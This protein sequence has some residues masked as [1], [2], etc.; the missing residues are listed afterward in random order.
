[1]R[2]LPAYIA[3]GPRDGSV[4][5]MPSAGLRDGYQ[6]RFSY[7]DDRPDEWYRLTHRLK[8]GYCVATYLG[9]HLGS[10]ST[11]ARTG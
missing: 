5:Q 3:G 11:G 4:H 10:P 7:A 9:D 8:D 1:M 6:V 2:Q